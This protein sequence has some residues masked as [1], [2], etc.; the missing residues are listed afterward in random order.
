MNATKNG[1]THYVDCDTE[2]TMCQLDAEDMTV[3]KK[4]VDCPDCIAM[5]ILHEINFVDVKVVRP[6]DL[7]KRQAWVEYSESDLC[8]EIRRLGSV[9]PQALALVAELWGVCKSDVDKM[10]MELLKRTKERGFAQ[11]LGGVLSYCKFGWP[12]TTPVRMLLTPPNMSDTEFR[13]EYKSG[14]TCAGINR[15]AVLSDEGIAKRRGGRVK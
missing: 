7:C 3:T 10:Q 11:N 6:S 13:K 9:S 1:I 2:T 12:D 4:D 15:K 14:S 5:F 8:V